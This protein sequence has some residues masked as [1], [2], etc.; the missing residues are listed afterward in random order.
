MKVWVGRPTLI[1]NTAENHC[2]RVSKCKSSEYK[3]RQAKERLADVWRSADSWGLGTIHTLR[4]CCTNCG[5]WTSNRG[6]CSEMQNPRPYPRPQRQNPHISKTLMRLICTVKFVKGSHMARH[7]G[8]PPGLI[9]EGVGGGTRASIL[10][11]TILRWLYR[12]F[13]V[14]PSLKTCGIE[15]WG[16][17]RGGEPQLCHSWAMW[18][19]HGAQCQ[20]K[21]V[22]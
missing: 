1:T 7:S 6:A 10:K 8:P 14:R 4:S 19:G 3:L 20:M 17:A 15:W 12:A 9:T 11:E 5:P 22:D 18:L 21:K 16:R 2:W 13:R